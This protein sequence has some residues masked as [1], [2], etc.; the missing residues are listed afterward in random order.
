MILKYILPLI[1][2]FSNFTHQSSQIANDYSNQKESIQYEENSNRVSIIDDLEGVFKEK[3]TFSFTFD[4]I[5]NINIDG[6]GFE[7][8]SSIHEDRIFITYSKIT[9]KTI[10]KIKFTFDSSDETILLF[11]D[12]SSNFTY[13]SFLSENSLERYMG[14]LNNECCDNDK[15]KANLCSNNNSSQKVI[16]LTNTSTNLN[17]GIINGY[18]KWKNSENNEFPLV[19]M[20]IKLETSIGNYETYTQDNGYYFFYLIDE[21]QSVNPFSNVKLHVYAKSESTSV[22][23][24]ETT[25]Y[26]K[27]WENIDLSQRSDGYELSYIF[28]PDKDKDLGKAMQIAQAAKYYSDYIKTLNNN[29]SIKSCT[30]NYPSNP[31]KGCH[32]TSSNETIYITSQTNKINSPLSYESWDTIGHEYGHHIQHVFSIANNPGGQHFSNKNDADYLVTNSNPTKN[33]KDN[34]LR[35]AWGESW[36]TYWA[37]TAQQTFPDDIK[38]INTVGDTNYTSYNGS[39]Y[40][41]NSYNSNDIKGEGCEQAI[42]RFLYKLY[43]NSIDEKDKFA[44]G[45]IKLWNIVVTTK[46]FYFYQFVG[47]LYSYGYSKSNLGLLL[48]AYGMSASNL[49]ISNSPTPST[50]PTFSWETQGGSLYFP[51][52]L[53]TL[54]FYSQNK[55][56]I[57]DI[58]NIKSNQYSLTTK[59]W[60]TILHAYGTKYYIMIESYASN[61]LSTG[62]YYSTFYEFSKPTNSDELTSSVTIYGRSKYYEKNYDILPNSY[63]TLKITFNTAGFKIIQT[64]GESDVYMS[65]YSSDETTL[66]A[67]NDDDG[68]GLNAWIYQ[69]LN[70]STTYVIKLHSYNKNNSIKTKLSV[71]PAHN[72]K[73]TLETSLSSYECIL[74]ITNTTNYYL[75]AYCEQ[76]YSEIITFTPT[77]SGNYTIDL[78]SQFD[79]YLHV[80]N[81]ESS[82]LLITNEDCNDDSN[83]TNASLAKSLNA[84]IKYYIVFGPYNPSL[85]MK[86]VNDYNKCSIHIYLN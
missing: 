80:I 55:V 21:T 64:F 59:Q 5:S 53:F 50:T 37:I 30:F 32:Y 42:M 33:D 43:S 68:Y 63:A 77:K 25:L 14:L 74:N 52:D 82:N 76:Y 23:H 38:K 15:L 20:K 66:I 29:I 47:A 1:G 34:G 35:L 86:N 84:D 28:D 70:S 26:E 56:K 19:G 36:P 71:T 60:D 48:E 2:L 27:C 11:F 40:S 73:D 69:Y 79:N 61:Y 39:N 54:S 58:T 8:S 16:S 51:N 83:G 85:E 12:F 18:M 46:P 4:S 41:L 44:I 7:Y 49:I 31:L 6:D 10:S 45:D 62:P 81:P 75:T 67:S 65:L 24:N 13:Y 57:V 17:V 9:A 78:T 72:F 3:K 22:I